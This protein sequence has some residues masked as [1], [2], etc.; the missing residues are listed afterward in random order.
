M[1]SQNER[2]ILIVMRHQGEELIWLNCI[3]NPATGK[4]A[5]YFQNRKDG[6]LISGLNVIMN[7]WKVC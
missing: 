5:F 3:S 1:Q 4:M 7:I 2:F 6:K